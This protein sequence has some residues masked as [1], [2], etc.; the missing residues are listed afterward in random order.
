MSTADGTYHPGQL[1]PSFFVDSV[2]TQ[3]AIV[4]R[5][6]SCSSVKGGISARAPESL[7]MESLMSWRFWQACGAWVRVASTPGI[8]R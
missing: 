6:C 8:W 7:T 1:V 4:S 2:E 5:S 3:R